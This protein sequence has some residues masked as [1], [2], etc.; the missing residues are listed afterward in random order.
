MKR[1]LAFFFLLALCALSAS[2]EEPSVTL[3]TETYE[4]FLMDNV[5]HDGAEGDIHYHLYVPDGKGHSRCS[6]HCRV[7]RGF[8]FRGWAST[9]ARRRSPLRH[10]GSCPT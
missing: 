2:A 5:L 10:G 1:F 7:T 3:G 4:G 6:S 8:T 9:C